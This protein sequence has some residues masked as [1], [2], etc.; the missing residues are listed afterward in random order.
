MYQ[1]TRIEGVR[2]QFVVNTASAV[3]SMRE[4][5]VPLALTIET[6]L[7]LECHGSKINYTCARAIRDHST[8]T[9]ELLT[10]GVNRPVIFERI[11]FRINL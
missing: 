4:P 10:G 1:T 7:C 6:A 9:S 2:S 8:L 11:E 3:L 5:V